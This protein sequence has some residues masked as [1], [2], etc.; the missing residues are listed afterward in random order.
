LQVSTAF[1]PSSAI[2]V[3]VAMASREIARLHHKQ[4]LELFV[5]PESR[6]GGLQSHSRS[7]ECGL[8]LEHLPAEQIGNCMM[9][10]AV[11]QLLH[12]S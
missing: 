8:F 7:T 5:R 1:V 3:M 2:G 12:V 6:P 11:H 9:A 4:L 10:N